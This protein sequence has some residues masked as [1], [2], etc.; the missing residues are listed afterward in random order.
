MAL[1]PFANYIKLVTENHKIDKTLKPYALDILRWGTKTSQN[2]SYVNDSCLTI[3][4]LLLQAAFDEE[5]RSF[6]AAYY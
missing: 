5:Q 6:Y 3:L 2:V 4:G 1:L